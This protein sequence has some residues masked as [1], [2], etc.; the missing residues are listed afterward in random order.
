MFVHRCYQA[1]INTFWYKVFRKA[2]SRADENFA[3]FGIKVVNFHFGLQKV[4]A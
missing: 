2:A 1:I 4:L 3:N